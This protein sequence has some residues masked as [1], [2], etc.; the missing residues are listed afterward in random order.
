MY[1]D[2]LA[3]ERDYFMALGTELRYSRE[4]K[5]RVGVT[6][7]SVP[8]LGRRLGR[9]DPAPRKEPQHTGTRRALHGGDVRRTEQPSFVK[10]HPFP[11]GTEDTID[12][13]VRR[14]LHEGQIPRPLQK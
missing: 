9:D 3:A 10:L 2:R 12:S 1:G 11:L 6:A 13:A 4:Q 8:H 14:V 7:F 5:E